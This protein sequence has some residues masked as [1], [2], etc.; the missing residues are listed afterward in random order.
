MEEAFRDCMECPEMVPIPAGSF[1]MGSTT[2]EGDGPDQHLVHV[3]AFSIGKYAVTFDEWDACVRA[4]GC[5]KKP[6]DM[7]WGRGRRPVINVS[8]NDAQQYV[9]WLSK[10]S[11]HKYRLPSEAEWEYAARAGT[12]TKY[13]WGD[14]IGTGHANCD[15][16]GSAWD[17]NRT[18]PVGSFAPNPWGLYD[19]LGNVWQLTQD[20]Y[21]DSYDGAPT[22]G[23]AWTSGDCSARVERG[24]SFWLAYQ[25]VS[26]AVRQDAGSPAFNVGFRVAR[27]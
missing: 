1:L 26:A 18:A 3:P 8:W 16:C 10:R 24:D 4:G 13:Y 21:H 23:S 19:M 2:N 11:H 20:C 7:G 17:D 9:R 15:D 5:S 22:D 14:N 6:R 27:D 25:V 12:T